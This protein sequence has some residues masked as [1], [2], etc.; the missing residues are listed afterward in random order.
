MLTA[1]RGAAVVTLAL[2]LAG[3]LAE[4]AAA[5]DSPGGGVVCPPTKLNCDVHAES[6][7]RPSSD[8]P[9][10]AS[11]PSGNTEG[12]QECVIDDKP[13]PCSSPTMG[14]FNG[15]DHCYWQA[16]DPPPAPDGPEWKLATGLP[17]NW[18]PGDKGALYNVTCPGIGRELMGGLHFAQNPPGGPA[19]DPAQ[20]AQQA[21]D[22]MTLRG[23]DIGITPKPG[24][25]GVVGMPVWMWDEKSA[26]T[27]G[28]NTASA[29]AGGITVTAT[30]RVSKIVWDLGDGGTVTC[31]SAGTPY[32]AEYGKRESPDCGYRYRQP[33]TS[34]SSGTYHVTATST[35]TIDWAGGGQ[36]GQ[37]IQT[38]DSAVDITVAEVQV[39]N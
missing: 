20:L 29:S 9:G 10:H 26:E 30:A 18:K 14:T 8:K 12:K 6:P 32:R 24:G 17:A 1:R 16:L 11:T 15:A 7:G 13:V 23:A 27:Y 37:I 38:R 28:P 39:L 31:T 36:N 2:A 33:S 4:S 35:W 5:D 25:K 21:V 19:V 22:K 3:L 34:K